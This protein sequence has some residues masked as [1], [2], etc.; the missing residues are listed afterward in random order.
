MNRRVAVD[1]RSELAARK[2]TSGNDAK[3]AAVGA[4]PD[5]ARRRGAAG[6]P[7]ALCARVRAGQLSYARNVRL[8]KASVLPQATFACA[9]SNLGV[10]SLL[11][12]CCV[13]G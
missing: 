1:V 2:P 11:K 3:R 12:P 9:S 4:M 7:I 6:W 10:V 13:P 5:S 8:N